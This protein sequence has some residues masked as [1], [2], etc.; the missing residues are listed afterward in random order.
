[1]TV[2]TL[3]LFGSPWDYSFGTLKIKVPDTFQTD[4]FQKGVKWALCVQAFIFTQK[5]GCVLGHFFSAFHDSNILCYSEYN[6][7][8]CS[9]NFKEFLF[10]H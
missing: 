3:L 1:M 10:V 4:G 7:V 6:F 8:I 9:L 2:L 5:S